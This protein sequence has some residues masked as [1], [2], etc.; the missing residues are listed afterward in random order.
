MSIL[1]FHSEDGAIKDDQL[2][3]ALREAN[4]SKIA[5]EAE[6][7]RKLAKVKE[8]GKAGITDDLVNKLREV[9]HRLLITI[10]KWEAESK[11]SFV[12][13]HSS[14]T[15]ETELESVGI[16]TWKLA[17]THTIKFHQKYKD[18]PVY[19]AQVS[20]EIDEENE[21]LAINSAIGIPTGIDKN[22]TIQSNELKDIIQNLTKRDLKNSILKSTLY[23]YFDSIRSQD[24]EH[25]HQQDGQWRLVYL[26][27][28]Q[29]GKSND[30]KMCESIQEMVDYVIDAHTGDL[31][32][33]LPR[34]KTIR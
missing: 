4:A 12:Q 23:Y 5:K 7:A 9:A 2:T 20:V 24:K 21:L 11:R 14:L 22:P 31:V 16:E 8:S 26:V 13:S 29:I 19:G 32:S 30:D 33:K 34:V 10:L 3:K 6:I 15:S 17:N 28:T 27:E 25:K 1:T 18:I